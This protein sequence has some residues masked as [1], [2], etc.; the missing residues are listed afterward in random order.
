M[1]SAHKGGQFRQ[2]L[3]YHALHYM[4]NRIILEIC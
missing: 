1:S 3:L 2:G 4:V